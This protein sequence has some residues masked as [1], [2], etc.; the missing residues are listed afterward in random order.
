MIDSNTEYVMEKVGA[1]VVAAGKSERMGGVEKIFAEID[2][3][4]LLAHTV[5][6]FQRC[7]SIDEIVIV[8][9]QS[10]LNIGLSLAKEYHWS[11]VSTVC[12][13]GARRQDSV[14]EG[15]QRLVR[16]KWVVIH[17]GA[18]PCLTQKLI[19]DGLREARDSGA[20]IPAVPVID[21]IKIVSSDS[22][23]KDTPPRD[24]LWA[25]QTPQVFR[26]DIISE[27]HRKAKDNV[28]DDA[29]LVERAGHKVKAFNGLN[30]NIKVTTP[31]DLIIAEAIIKSRKQ[32]GS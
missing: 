13:G 4:P 29:S 2:G 9:S 7:P 28:T 16:C 12:P 23:V 25:V 5:E 19:T 15:L 3:K 8:L 26:F 21:T 20:A 14:N 10:K 32:M 24:K 6:V 31:E 17:D 1:I 18:R 27:A 11:K 22:Y 30:T